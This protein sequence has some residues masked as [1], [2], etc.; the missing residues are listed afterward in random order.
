MMTLF[1]IL[2]LRDF[3]TFSDFVLWSRSRQDASNL[4]SISRLA[5]SKLTSKSKA[6]LALHDHAMPWNWNVAG[7]SLD[8]EVYVDYQRYPLVI[9]GDGESTLKNV[10]ASYS[11]LE[12]NPDSDDIGNL[13]CTLKSEPQKIKNEIIRT[14]GRQD[15]INHQKSVGDSCCMF[16]QK[17]L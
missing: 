11:V 5:A 12:L 9:D 4:H 10:L 17:T 16:L 15:R 2:H 14:L 3:S 8:E 1:F 7:I 13:L 6:A